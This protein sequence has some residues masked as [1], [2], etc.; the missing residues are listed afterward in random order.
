MPKGYFKV[1]QRHIEEMG[2]LISSQF[3]F[4]ARHSTL[5]YMR[6]TDHVALSMNK[7]VFDCGVFRYR[8]RLCHHVAL[9]LA[10]LIIKLHLRPV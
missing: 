5:Q 6:F 3:S 7:I 4:R 2:L 8:R 9:T 1:V 10:V